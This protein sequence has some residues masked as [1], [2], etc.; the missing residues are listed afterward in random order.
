MG[1]PSH[2]SESTKTNIRKIATLPRGRGTIPK[3]TLSLRAETE[4][5]AIDTNPSLR[6]EITS[7]KTTCPS[8][9][10]ADP[11]VSGKPFERPT[12]TIVK[13]GANS[14]NFA[15]KKN[16]TLVL[17]HSLDHKK[18]RTSVCKLRA[19]IRTIVKYGSL[20]TTNCHK[21]RIGSPVGV[22]RGTTSRTPSLN[23]TRL[24]KTLGIEETSNI[25]S[26]L[27]SGDNGTLAGARKNNSDID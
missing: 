12:N 16:V 19:K 6:G 23:P 22:A 1:T 3:R 14:R 7:S 21:K 17:T 15:L 5:P 4:G 9:G 25:H 11:I 2:D 27:P 8:R 24:A 13:N 10:S 18:T 26:E 20:P